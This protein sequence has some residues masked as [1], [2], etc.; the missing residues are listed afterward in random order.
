MP[1]L[2]THASHVVRAC[3]VLFTFRVQTC[4]MIDFGLKKMGFTVSEFCRTC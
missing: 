2:A 1:P 3:M 4:S